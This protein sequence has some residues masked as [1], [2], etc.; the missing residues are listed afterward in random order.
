MTATFRKYLLALIVFILCLFN[1]QSPVWAADGDLDTTFGD[2]GIVITSK[3]EENSYESA[4]A[5]A[6]QPD[7]KII[8]VGTTYKNI[9]GDQYQHFQVVRYKDDGSLD[10]E[11]GVGGKV[12]NNFT[13]YRDEALSVALQTDGKIV[14]AGTFIDIRSGNSYI[15]VVRYKD[16]GSLDEEFG[17]GGIVKTVVEDESEGRFVFIQPDHKIVVAG[18]SSLVGNKSFLVARYQADGSLDEDFDGDGI[19]LTPMSGSSSNYVD[20]A[21]LQPD[22]KILVAGA[23]YAGRSFETVV[24]YK[25]DGSL[26]EE[27][28]VGGIVETEV[29]DGGRA[30][31]VLLQ[32][33][34]KIVT[35][36]GTYSGCCDLGSVVRYKDDGSLDEDFGVGGTV[37]VTPTSGYSFYNVSGVLQSDGKILVS[38]QINNDVTDLMALFR[39][40]SDG[41]T[42]TSFGDDGQIE[43]LVGTEGSEPGFVVL[44][45]D[46]KIVVAGTAYPD[47]AVVRYLNGGGN[48]VSKTVPWVGAQS[49][50]CPAPNPWVREKLGFAYNAEPV[51]V[52]AE[53]TVGKTITQGS[54]DALKSSGVVFDT[55]SNKVSTATETLPIYGCKDKLLSGKVNQ[56]IQFIAGGYT[57][58]SDAHGYINTADLKWHD[59]NGVT[60][61]TNTAAFMH[62]IKFTKTGKYVVVLTEQPDTSRGLIPTYGVRSVRFVININ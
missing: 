12:N 41:S 60:L 57:L 45:S 48:T 8:V 55:V 36:G 52:S 42:D 29:L 54:Y 30:Y 34:G 13:V 11:F 37:I 51:L 50:T 15:G 56:P 9:P 24:R 1:L 43:T 46:G 23:I 53:N 21:V 31:S 10:E 59:T 61:Y 32:P 44:Q 27:F 3:A 19:A 16:D 26:D 6:L 7:G 35:V 22:G 62:T 2:G 28:G 20:S 39:F 17:V 33:D 4:K 40:N 14:V 47:F 5:L 58:Q 18:I 49:I 38:S 25:D